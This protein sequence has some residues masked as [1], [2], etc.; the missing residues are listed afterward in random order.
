MSPRQRQAEAFRTLKTDGDRVNTTQGYFFIVGCSRSGTTLLSVL[1][2]RHSRLCV[3]P[4]TAF[5][6]EVAPL[7]TNRNDESLINVLANWS[8][9]CELQI[10]PEMVRRRLGTRPEPGD[11][12]AAILDLYALHRGKSRC[13]EKTPQHLAHI[14]SILRHFPNAKVICMLRD[15]RDTSLSLAEMPWWRSGVAEAAELWKQSLRRMEEF[16]HKYYERFLVLRYEDLLASPEQA[17][18]GVMEYL[19]ETFEPAQLRS[20]TPSHVVLK[21]SVEWKGKALDPIDFESVG[22]RRAEARA[23]D[24]EFLEQALRDDL[25]L[26]GYEP[27]G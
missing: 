17:L 19:G 20:E 4:E 26:Y 15:G 21:R 7:L 9:L 14:P 11:V 23:A 24:L 27:M 22:R 8:R 10:E 18:S 13:G 2:D 12:L 3:T 16:Q 5:F 6:D 1:I 25:A